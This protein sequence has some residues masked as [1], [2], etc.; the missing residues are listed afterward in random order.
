MQR[1]AAMRSGDASSAAAG[2]SAPGMLC[3]GGNARQP[4]GGI[5]FKVLNTHSDS[6]PVGGSSSPPYGKDWCLCTQ[7]MRKK[8][9]R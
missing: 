9:C 8:L 2:P 7:R 5:L 4:G 3:S 6:A 1:A